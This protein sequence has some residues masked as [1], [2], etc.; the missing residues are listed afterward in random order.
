M[1]SGKS[2]LA[3]KKSRPDCSRPC[4]TNVIDTDFDAAPSLRVTLSKS[5][6]DA[7]EISP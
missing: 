3:K 7:L 5:S 1:K 2:L 6:D 4:D